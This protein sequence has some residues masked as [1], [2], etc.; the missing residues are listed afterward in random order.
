MQDLGSEGQDQGHFIQFQKKNSQL[1]L[2][3]IHIFDIIQGMSKLQ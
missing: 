1:I 2:H 3:E